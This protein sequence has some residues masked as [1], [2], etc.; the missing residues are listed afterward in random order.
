[1]AAPIVIVGGGQAGLQVAESL[2]AEGYGGS[3]LIVGEEPHAP[4]QR[5]PL[6][7]E[8]LTGQMEERQLWIRAPAALERKSI[9]LVTGRR[10]LS[11]DRQAQK[12]TLDN[13]ETLAYSALALTTGARA[14]MLPVP[15]A[16]LA[17]VM[18]L[19]SLDD[20]RALGLALAAAERIA[21]VGGGF[22][23][24]EIASAARKHGKPVTVFEAA[25][26]L[27]ARAVSPLISQVFAELHESHGVAIHFGAKA[28]EFVG[29]AGRVTGVAMADGTVHPADLVVVGAGARANDE[30]AAACGLACDNG[31]VVD[32]CARTTDPLIVA[33]GDCTARRQADGALVRLE[34]VQ[35]A[36]EQGKSAAAA[37]MGR[38]RLFAG[39]PWFWSDQHGI[40][41]QMAGRW[42]GYEQVAI[43]GSVEARCFT[44]CYFRAGKLT[45]A[46][47]L[48]S[49]LDHMRVRKLLEGNPT[50]TPTQAANEGF[51]LAAGADRPRY[52][53]YPQGM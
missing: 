22:I 34:S 6:S 46:D 9:Q 36:A 2:R 20:S 4:Y 10:V 31:I 43:R 16:H 25:D 26:R 7:K 35:N 1:V 33:A 50:L 5:P 28:A 32:E 49:P 38:E 15:G 40:K 52:A 51:N 48:G 45:G 41:L 3:L 47:S 17:G 19:R 11:M 44:A 39:P 30:L 13:G 23:G 18:A 42:Q 8:F 14:R 37:L 21:I 29:E 27:M 12:L 53:S 24:L